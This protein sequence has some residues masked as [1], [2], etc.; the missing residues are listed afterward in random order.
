MIVISTG[1]NF[2]QALRF[3]NLESGSFAHVPFSGVAGERLSCGSRERAADQP[4]RNERAPQ[5]PP[6][7]ASRI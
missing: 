1:L 6:L 4:D 5:W 3:S 7:K 2:A